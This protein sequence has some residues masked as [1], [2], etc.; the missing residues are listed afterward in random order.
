MFFVKENH[1][2][3]TFKLDVSEESRVTKAPILFSSLSNQP[4]SCRNIEANDMTRIR[5]VNASPLL[6]KAILLTH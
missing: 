5:I 1:G 6:E 4:I 3:F 2:F